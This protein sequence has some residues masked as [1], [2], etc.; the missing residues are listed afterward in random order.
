MFPRGGDVFV[1]ELISRAPPLPLS[2][3]VW[4]SNTLGS[5]KQSLS[6]SDIL[7]TS[8]TPREPGR[9]EEREEER[10]SK[11]TGAYLQ[12]QRRNRATR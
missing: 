1:Y 4:S 7:H 9:T 2:P 3:S 8:A 12:R 11:K 10:E 6:G 5:T